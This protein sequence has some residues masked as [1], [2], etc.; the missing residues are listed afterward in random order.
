MKQK[1]KG[2][3][4]EWIPVPP[5]P[6]DV[7]KIPI[8]YI[9]R[10]VK[11]YGAYIYVSLVTLSRYWQAYQSWWKVWRPRANKNIMG[12]YRKRQEYPIIYEIWN[13]VPSYIKRG[14]VWT[15]VIVSSCYTDIYGT[16]S[17]AKCKI[18]HRSR[19]SVS[20]YTQSVGN[21]GIHSEIQR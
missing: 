1:K 21:S 4:K 16:R 15:D 19:C 8:G 2:K 18:L 12:F 11:R 20:C 14:I 7:I 9:S 3:K 17:W 13:S 6:I 10:G 5:T